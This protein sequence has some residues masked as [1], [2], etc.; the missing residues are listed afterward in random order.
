MEKK[1]PKGI[2]FLHTGFQCHNLKG[3]DISEITSMITEM[4]HIH[5][6]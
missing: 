3:N 6:P 5:D 4:K 1:S 2:Y